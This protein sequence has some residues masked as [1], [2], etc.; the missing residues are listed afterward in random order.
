MKNSEQN[1]HVKEITQYHRKNMYNNSAKN[2]SIVEHYKRML[3]AGIIKKRMPVSEIN[4]LRN[5][6]KRIEN[7]NRFWSVETYETN[8][9]KVLLRTFLCKDRFCNNCNQIKRLLLQNRFLPYM[10]QYQNTLYHI[11]LTVPDCTG[12][13]LKNTIHN[14]NSCFKTLVSYLN[15]NKKVK[16]IDLTQYK[17]QGCLRSLEITYNADVY[18]PHFHIV[19]V[20]E[21][22][23]CVENK[24]IVNEFSNRGTRQFSEFE[25]IIQRM[26]W[27]LINKKRLTSDNILGTHPSL[28]RYSCIVDKIEGTDYEKIFGYMTKMYSYDN[29]FMTYENF[30]HLYQALSR[31]RLIQGYGVFYN[32]KEPKGDTYTEN[33]YQAIENYFLYQEEPTNSYESLSHLANEQDYLI[34]KRKVN[35][36]LKY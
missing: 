21:N 25:V 30:K 13:N 24:H 10:A 3:V 7:C 27:L 31:I 11:V 6:M 16:G 12:N 5:R 19:A 2:N 28:H 35:L 18:H 34:L 1:N 14:M 9:V 29:R 36:N 15:G 4:I 32:I 17:F 23:S 22:E 8:H 33:D 20:F 26:W